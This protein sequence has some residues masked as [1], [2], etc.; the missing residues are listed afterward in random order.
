MAALLVG[1]IVPDFV[2]LTREGTSV[3]I[4]DYRGKRNLVLIFCGAGIS[5]P[6]RSLLRDVSESYREFAAEEVELFAVVQGADYKDE[7]LDRGG[8]LAFPFLLD[9]LGHVHDLFGAPASAQ[10]LFPLAGIVDR[11]GELRHVSRVGD[12]GGPFGA[13]EILD[14]VRYINLECP[15]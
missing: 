3:R 1:E 8:T 11:Y 15:E 4:S 13:H 9:R 7:D 10:D 14:W 5:G 12:P 6:V 2:L